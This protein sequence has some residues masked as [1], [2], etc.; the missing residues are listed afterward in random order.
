M[1][2]LQYFLNNLQFIMP[3]IYVKV[4]TVYNFCWTKPFL[5]QAGRDQ[6]TARKSEFNI[7]SVAF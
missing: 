2:Y 6:A 7:L 4:L 5:F 1:D 3:S